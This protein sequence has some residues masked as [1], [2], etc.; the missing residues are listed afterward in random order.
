MNNLIW[1]KSDF[2]NA[3][4]KSLPVKSLHSNGQPRAT[5]EELQVEANNAQWVEDN[6]EGLENVYMSSNPPVNKENFERSFDVWLSDHTVEEL[7]ELIK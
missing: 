5:K 3:L 1:T 2:V 4:G 7:K 6:I